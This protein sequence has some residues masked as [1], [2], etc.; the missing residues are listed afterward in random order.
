[1][2]LFLNNFKST[3]NTDS[4]TEI[5]INLTNQPKQITIFLKKSAF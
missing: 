2:G 1:M 4:Y 5:C 3:I